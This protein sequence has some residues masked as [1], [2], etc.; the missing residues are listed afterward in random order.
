MDTAAKPA[1]QHWESLQDD[2]DNQLLT[3]QENETSTLKIAAL[4]MQCAI[5]LLRKLR[6]SLESY[7]FQNDEE[8]VFYKKIEPFFL[9]RVIFYNKL[10]NLE[11]DKPQTD[12]IGLETYLKKHLAN[13]ETLY[14]RHRFIY[15]YIRS[16]ATY[17]D[18]QLFFHPGNDSSLAI[19]GLEPPVEDS[20]QICYNHIVAHLQAADFL[21][22]YI[23]QEIEI[24]RQPDTGNN[25]KVTWTAKIV[26][27]IELGYVLHASGVLNNG[28]LTLKE[29]MEFLE[30]V[31]HVNIGNYPR[32]FQ[33]ILCRKG[34]YTVFQDKIKND[35]LLYIQC[36]ENRHERL[37]S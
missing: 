4:S 28:K 30:N 35:Y 29:T 26:G 6:T 1:S 33:E 10:Y 2:L 37:P 14:D 18:R 19:N 24:L 25:S 13:L 17:L 9:S 31:M 27:L 23:L 12:T 36:I 16:G 15:R 3:I 8:I 7:I 20:V 22:K 34:G 11:M 5:D 21:N 32:S